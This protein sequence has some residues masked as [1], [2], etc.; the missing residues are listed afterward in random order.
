MTESRVGYNRIMVFPP[1]CRAHQTSLDEEIAEAIG[2]LGKDVVRVRYSLGED[3]TG[4]PA[5][6]YRVLLTDAASRDK[7]IGPVSFQVMKVLD[8]DLGLLGEWGLQ[9]YFNFRGKSEQER[10]RDP[11]WD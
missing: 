10:R 5:I 6:F 8:Q 1:T 2:K 9:S 4:E 7:N 11:S 3:S